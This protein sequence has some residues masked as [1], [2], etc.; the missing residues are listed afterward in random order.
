MSSSSSAA[1]EPAADGVSTYND[2]S[3][4]KSLK[5]DPVF[6]RKRSIEMQTDTIQC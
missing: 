5:D 6:Y 3:H 2:T 1:D 4:M